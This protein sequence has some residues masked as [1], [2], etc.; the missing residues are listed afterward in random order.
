THPIRS[1][2]SLGPFARQHTRRAPRELPPRHPSRPP[3]GAASLL[4]PG[5]R[6]MT[7]TT[8]VIRTEALT[9]VYPGDLRAVDGLDLEVNEGE[10]FGL[11]GPN[12]AGKTTTV[13]MLTTRVIPTSGRAT[14]GGIDVWAHPSLTKQVIGG[15]SQTNQLDRGLTVRENLLL[16]G[17][18]FGMS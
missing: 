4:R 12:G 1:A 6:V 16:H 7:A 9:K 5:W 18:S 10:I 14:V 2:L 13:G 11:L 15:V 3:S 8:P 17:L